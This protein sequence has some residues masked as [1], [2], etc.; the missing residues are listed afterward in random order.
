[1][2][3]TIGDL[4]ALGATLKTGPFGTTLAASEYSESGVPV[5]SVGE[6][7]DGQIV[8]SDRT[9]RVGLGV[10]SRLNEYL[11]KADDIVFARKGSVERTAR[12]R[13]AEA[14]WL[15]GSDG[16]R[17]R[18]GRA[19]D[20]AFVAFQL[21]SGTVREW[22]LQHAGGSTLR[23]LNQKTICRVPITLP[24]LPTQRAI[25]EVLGALDDKIAANAAI[26]RGVD[27]LLEAE[28]LGVQRD[29][30]TRARLGDLVALRYGKAL[31]ATARV[32]GRVQVFGSGGVAGTHAERLCQGPGIIVGRKGTVG[33]VYWSDD[34]FYPIDTVF[35][36]ES[37]AGFALEYLYFLLRSLRLNELNSDSAVPGLNRDQ[38]YAQPVRVGRDQDVARF[39]ALA[40]VLFARRAQAS[41]ESVALAELRDTLLPH[42]MSGRLTVREAEKQVEVA[43]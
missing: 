2:S 13:E 21:R 3:T 38:A 33:A 1:M 34:D 40:R 6:V 26:A 22:L 17:L 42:L 18:V 36:V 27:E 8:I 32:P 43:L 41:R 5:V 11:L 29:S 39:N 7:G 24:P 20:A 30:D 12:V 31:P 4:L 25:A 28:F 15:L 35:Y 9:R 16:L 14:G 23:S 19:A 37:L 10:T